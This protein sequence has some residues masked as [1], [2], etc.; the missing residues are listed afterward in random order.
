MGRSNQD[1]AEAK[2]QDIEHSPNIVGMAAL[3]KN[4]SK[5]FQKQFEEFLQIMARGEQVSAS[6]SGNK[7]LADAVQKEFMSAYDTFM[8]RYSDEIYIRPLRDS[9]PV[10][11]QLTFTH[12]ETQDLEKVVT[13]IYQKKAHTIDGVQIDNIIK[14][15]KKAIRLNREEVQLDNSLIEITPNLF[16]DGKTGD[17]SDTPNGLCARRL[18]DT[19]MGGKNIVKY[20]PHAFDEYKGKIQQYANFTLQELESSNG[21]LREDP[22]L[23][24]ISTWADGNHETYMDILRMFASNFMEP[25]PFGV[26]ML[27]G[28][29]RNGKSVC[30]GLLH[31]LFGTNNT[32]RIQIKQ[33]GEW[34][35]NLEFANTL[36]NAPDEE[37]NKIIEDQAL[38][39]SL[40]DH[41]EV[42]L[43]RMARQDALTVRGDF[44]IVVPMNHTPKWPKDGAEACIR[45]TRIIAF[46]ADLSKEDAKPVD[47]AKETFTPKR[48]AFLLGTVL[49]IA[50]YYLS[51]PFPDSSA[52]VEEREALEKE[53]VSGKVYRERLQK[54]FNGY[55]KRT[56]K[57][58]Y[59]LWCQ[60]KNLPKQPDNSFARL[61]KKYEIGNKKRFS[62]SYSKSELGYRI[63]S[64]KNLLYDEF[65]IPERNNKTIGQ[66]HD[67]GFSVVTILDQIYDEEE[68]D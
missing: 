6:I 24:F 55:K 26:Y 14:S 5:E 13:G 21:D 46:N 38:F 50:K 54:Y 28:E 20:E 17:F 62:V 32:T 31:T 18:F 65:K 9:A 15:I 40:A 1:R 68:D 10:P 22:R 49:G 7:K 64:G 23:D 61:F 43:A 25:K 63:N 29:G 66:C 16:W 12:L 11:G 36:L 58:D 48:I 33:L 41:G 60:N 37:E 35:Y 4:Q 34:H 59:E 57:K 2:A 47:F 51:H 30:I 67:E 3:A 52:M 39:K 27:V 56:L 45:R 8:M 19:K 42:K 44:M 53:M